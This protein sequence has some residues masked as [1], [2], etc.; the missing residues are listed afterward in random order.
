MQV[1]TWCTL[2]WERPIMVWQGHRLDRH[3]ILSR[4]YSRGL[5]SLSFTQTSRQTLQVELNWFS[6]DVSQT[7]SLWKISSQNGVWHGESI[8]NSE[9]TVEFWMTGWDA[10]LLHLLCPSHFQPMGSDW[11]PGG[12]FVFP[13]TWRSPLYALFVSWLMLLAILLKIIIPVYWNRRG[14]RCAWCKWE[15]TARLAF[16][17]YRYQAMFRGKQF[18]KC[19]SGLLIHQKMLILNSWNEKVK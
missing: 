14:D 11:Q 6:V 17:K 16:K 19:L 4:L 12:T 13:C 2:Y 1:Q 8:Y 5:T 15:M 10:L 18:F 7:F 9:Y 3:H